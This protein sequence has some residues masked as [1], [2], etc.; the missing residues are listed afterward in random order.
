MDDEF[1][2][3]QLV[4]GLVDSLCVVGIGIGLLLL[5]LPR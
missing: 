1:N 3:S 4:A 5:L 2:W